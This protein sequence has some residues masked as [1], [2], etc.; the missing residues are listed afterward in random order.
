MDAPPRVSAA[1]ASATGWVL[2]RPFAC[3]AV[4][5]VAVVARADAAVAD[6]GPAAAVAFV[7]D[8]SSAASA[9]PVSQEA[10]AA[11]WP[12]LEGSR[13]H[14]G[15]LAADPSQGCGAGHPRHVDE[16]V[17]EPSRCQPSG[18]SASDRSASAARSIASPSYVERGERA[19]G[20]QE[21][22]DLVA[23]GASFTPEVTASAARGSRPP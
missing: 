8:I 16:E 20:H 9:C 19:D 17:P 3:P 15:E 21:L 11:V 2:L 18:G 5:P 7:A 6:A 13:E 12:R 1:L 23:D 10:D 4:S 14:V 22:H